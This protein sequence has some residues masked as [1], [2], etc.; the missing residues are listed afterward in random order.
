M[1]E[2]TTGAT[3]P[4]DPAIA[5]EVA[6]QKEIILRGAVDVISEAEL[7]AKL[8]QSLRDGKPLRVK[9]GVDPTSSSLH[10]GFTVV[11]NKLRDFQDLGHVAVLILGDATAM[12]GDPTGRNKTRPRLKHEEIVA[13]AKGYLGQASKVLDADRL[14]VHYNSE[15]LHQLDFE[16]LV[17]L[18]ARYTVARM[19][20]RNDFSQRY[21]DGTPIYLHEFVYP[22]LQG[23]DS[24]E[25]DADVE[26]G[27]SDQLF[28]LLVGRDLQEQEDQ[29]A[30]FC[31]TTPLLLGLDGQLKMSKSYGNAVGIDEPAEEMFKKI[32]R[33]DDAMMRD[34]FVLLTRESMSEIDA[35]LKDGA[36][37]RDVKMRLGHVLCTRYHDAAAADAAQAAWISQV[38][39]KELPADL[40]AVAVGGVLTDGQASVVDLLMLAFPDLKSR[41]EAR[42]LM[43]GGGVSLSGDKITDPMAIVTVQGDEILK[44]GKRRV[45]KLTL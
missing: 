20:E 25:I 2:P 30:Q 36:N 42:R 23:W 26:L 41:G 32:M 7:E 15:W 19:L 21:K 18:T 44:A 6:R 9:L 16:G 45:A 14:E 28:N 5:K 17:G 43:K 8:T 37:P 31:L 4:L 33:V 24:V 27:G 1:T 35:L 12:V 40:P 39:K 34:W 13:H 10:L 22:L 3:E 38:S 11:L 29:P